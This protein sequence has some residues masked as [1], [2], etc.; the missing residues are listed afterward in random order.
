M[1][2]IPFRVFV[3]LTKR[4]REIYSQCQGECLICLCEGDCDLAKKL[5]KGVQG[6][7]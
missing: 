4:E 2:A 5:Y 3:K 1:A 7:R 6:M